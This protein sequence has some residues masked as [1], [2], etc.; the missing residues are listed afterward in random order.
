MSAPH[1]HTETPDTLSALFQSIW[2]AIAKRKSDN[3]LNDHLQLKTWTHQHATCLCSETLDPGLNISIH[4]DP[5]ASEEL[6]QKANYNM[7]VKMV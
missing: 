1:G 3:Y 2:T 7:R 5:R 4:L 6:L